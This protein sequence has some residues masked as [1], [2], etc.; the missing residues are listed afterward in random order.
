[1]I[2][3]VFWS[4]TLLIF[5][6]SIRNYNRLSWWHAGVLGWVAVMVVAA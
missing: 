4:A 6:K 3:I 1:M 2:P 5:Y